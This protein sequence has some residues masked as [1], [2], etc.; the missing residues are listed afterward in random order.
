[1]VC[2]V[3]APSECADPDMT[4][5]DIEPIIAQRC[6]GCHDGRG[7]Q[8]PLLD[9]GHVAAWF[10]EIRSAMLSCAMPPP[11]SGLTMPV[12]EREAL[13]RWIRCGRPR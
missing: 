5:A 12:E 10:I 4:F 7:D 9:Y 11:D 6:L 2:D 13:L 3:R 1:L 8:W